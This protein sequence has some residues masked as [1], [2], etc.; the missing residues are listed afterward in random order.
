MDNTDETGFSPAIRRGRISEL[1]IIE[2]TDTELDI[3][4]TASSESLH[5]NFALSLWSVAVTCL[6][7]LLTTTQKYQIIS[8]I[9][10]IF[11]IIGFIGGL[12]LFCIW[13]RSLQNRIWRRHDNS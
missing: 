7:A 11:T 10:L 1:K 3:L 9:F 2:I 4:A 8:S 5:L 6:V 13:F 12:L